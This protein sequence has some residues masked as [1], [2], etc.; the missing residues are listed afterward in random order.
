[1]ILLTIVVLGWQL[2][3]V[4]SKEVFQNSGPVLT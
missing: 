2:L 1:M 3:V 4:I